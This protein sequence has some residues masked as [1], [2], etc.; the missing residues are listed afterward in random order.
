LEVAVT[1]LGIFLLVVGAT[2][3]VIET[4]VP[5]LGMLG[6][7]G[8][9]AL[10]VGA[11]L[12]VGGLGGGLGV[13]LATAL[14]LAFAGTGVLVLALRKG[15]AVRRRRISTG[16]ESLVGQVGVVRSWAD[17]NGRV[18]IDGALWRARRAWSDDDAEADLHEGDAI[19]VERLSG[20]TL[21]VRRAEEWEL[22]P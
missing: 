10:V 4:H 5:A 22:A 14:I 13:V 21:A 12:A 2:L 17:P 16:P 20:L 6:G 15:A 1:A 19:V 8:V 18:L 7:P 3:V 9:A 11:V